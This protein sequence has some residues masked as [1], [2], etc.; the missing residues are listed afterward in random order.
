MSHEMPQRIRGDFK[1]VK[2]CDDSYCMPF[3]RVNDI[4]G[5]L[6]VSPEQ[7]HNSVDPGPS[8]QQTSDT[9]LWVGS[10]EYYK[11]QRQ[12]GRYATESDAG[13]MDFVNNIRV[14]H[15]GQSVA[16]A[17]QS[18]MINTQEDLQILQWDLEH[19]DSFPDVTATK[20]I[21]PLAHQPMFEFEKSDLINSET[22]W[23]GAREIVP[24]DIS[25]SLSSSSELLDAWKQGYYL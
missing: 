3:G 11:A 18:E 23:Y 4:A 6:L 24:V 22:R 7:L 15:M 5:R 20:V 19:E 10:V 16:K 9:L 14:L 1:R 21:T 2:R 12:A 13:D 25:M 8:N 17:I